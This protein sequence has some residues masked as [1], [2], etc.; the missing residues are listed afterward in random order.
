M[1][2]TIGPT[3]S[4]ATTVPSRTPCI[5]DKKTIDSRHANTTSVMSNPSFTYPKSLRRRREMALT[6]Y[7][8]DIMAISALTSK[9]M[10]TE[11][12][13]HPISNTPIRLMYATGS[14]HE[15]AFIDTSIKVPKHSEMGICN[16]Y[17]LKSDF[18]SFR[19]MKNSSSA[20]NNKFTIIVHCPIVSGVNMLATYVTLVMGEVPSSAFVMNA[21]PKA[22][23]NIDT[24]NIK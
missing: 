22:F 9:A 15:S 3:S 14:S 17:I 16:R 4:A 21:M 8:P 2:C 5:P 23:T 13:T 11:R 20:T 7:S 19:D 12:I 10:P 6:K 24:T 1:K 18:N